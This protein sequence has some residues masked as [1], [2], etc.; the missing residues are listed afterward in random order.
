MLIKR[1]AVVLLG[2]CGGGDSPF[3][4]GGGGSCSLSEKILKEGF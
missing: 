3:I 2:P 1:R 4:Q